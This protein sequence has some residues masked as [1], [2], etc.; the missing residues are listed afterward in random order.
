MRTDPERR[1][2]QLVQEVSKMGARGQGGGISPQ[3]ELH[4]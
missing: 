3:R 4:V 2:G 1:S